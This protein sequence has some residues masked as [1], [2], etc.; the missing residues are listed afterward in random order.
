M[1]SQ[2]SQLH[3]PTIFLEDVNSTITDYK[4]YVL[5]KINTNTTL[6]LEKY[7]FEDADF[8]PVFLFTE[9]FEVQVRLLHTWYTPAQIKCIRISGTI[10]ARNKRWDDVNLNILFNTEEII[11]SINYPKL[12]DYSDLFRY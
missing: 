12:N 11:E 3:D 2:C 6:T 8:K 10:Q 1:G 4:N 9:P 5:G 7:G